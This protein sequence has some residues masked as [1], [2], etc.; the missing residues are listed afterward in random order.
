MSEA[1]VARLGLWGRLGG[2]RKEREAGERQPLL[3]GKT[4]AWIV[5]RWAGSY[6]GRVSGP[7]GR[8]CRYKTPICTSILPR[9]SPT[10]FRERGYRF[11]FF[12]REEARM[13][14][15][16]MSASGEAKFWLEPEIAVARS[17]GLSPRELARIRR[18]IKSHEIELCHAWQSH[19]GR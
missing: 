6:K 11:F 5:A 4:H 17:T 3:G 15:H 14:V 7:F 8:V 9:M 2:S 19:F 18:I 12:S 10:I 13:H 1:D 16:V